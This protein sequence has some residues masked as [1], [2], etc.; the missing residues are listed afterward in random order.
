MATGRDTACV[1]VLRDIELGEEITCFYGQ[2]FFGDNNI[3]CEC[4]TCERRKL[5]AFYESCDAAASADSANGAL[6]STSQLLLEQ[7]RTVLSVDGG[8]LEE[9]RRQLLL[10]AANNGMAVS[11]SEA[12]QSGTAIV[13]KLLMSQASAMKSARYRL[14]ETTNRINRTRTATTSGTTAAGTVADASALDRLVALVTAATRA[15]TTAK[16]GEAVPVVALNT[17]QACSPLTMKDLREKGITKYDAEMIIAQQHTHQRTPSVDRSPKKATPSKPESCDTAN[18]LTYVAGNQSSGRS[19]RSRRGADLVIAE[20]QRNVIRR[21]RKR[22]RSPQGSVCNE[23]EL[24]SAGAKSPRSNPNVSNADTLLKTP[25]RQRLKLTLRMKR[26]PL[27]DVIEPSDRGSLLKS[28]Q[29]LFRPDGDARADGSSELLSQ[30]NGPLARDLG[31]EYEVYRMEGLQDCDEEPNE[32]SEWAAE[33]YRSDNKLMPSKKRKKRKRRH[34]HKQHRQNRISSGDGDDPCCSLSSCSSSRTYCTTTGSCSSVASLSHCPVHHHNDNH[35]VA[36]AIPTTPSSSASSLSMTTQPQ[37]PPFRIKLKFG[38][39]S[40][41]INIPA[42]EDHQASD[43]S[44][45]A[46]FNQKRGSGC[47]EQQQLAEDRLSGTVDPAGKLGRGVASPS[48]PPLL[49]N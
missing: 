45:R 41:T 33:S 5:G 34:H 36:P 43:L 20:Q 26:S 39:E 48:S 27:L 38:N 9:S 35:S 37:T 14:R 24:R 44:F 16:E 19:L 3:Y 40:R 15:G 17:S 23:E 4:E 29:F 49:V 30:V 10:M 2:D 12:S 25:E 21:T 13:N 32:G 18:S 47:A 6:E 28:R 7:L 31:A 42:A 22:G 8:Q 46:T 11:D 1:K